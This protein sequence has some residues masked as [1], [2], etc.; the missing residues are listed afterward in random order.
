M[1]DTFWFSRVGDIFEFVAISNAKDFSMEECDSWTYC[2]PKEREQSEWDLLY[3]LLVTK[4]RMTM[5]GC[6]RQR[7]GLAKTY[8]FAFH[9][10]SFAPGHQWKETALE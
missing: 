9:H 7:A 5:E 6:V 1:L 3:A 8:Q 4:A 2:V 10:N